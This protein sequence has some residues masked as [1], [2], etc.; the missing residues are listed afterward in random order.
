VTTIL[1]FLKAV[2]DVHGPFFLFEY[3]RHYGFGRFMGG[4]AREWLFRFEPAGRF[5]EERL[6]GN[7]QPGGRVCRNPSDNRGDRLEKRSPP[8]LKLRHVLPKA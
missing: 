4:T 1:K 3:C 6:A 8:T 7:G 2:R 5:R